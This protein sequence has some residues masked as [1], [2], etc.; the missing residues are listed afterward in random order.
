MKLDKTLHNKSL[1]TTPHWIHLPSSKT[2]RVVKSIDCLLALLI[3][4][5]F[6]DSV[7]HLTRHDASVWH[8]RNVSPASLQCYHPWWYVPTHGPWGQLTN[9]NLRSSYVPWDPSQAT[10]RKRPM[11]KAPGLTRCGMIRHVWGNGSYLYIE[12]SWNIDIV[13]KITST[14]WRKFYS[15]IRMVKLMKV[16]MSSIVCVIILH[17]LN[18]CYMLTCA[19]KEHSS[20]FVLPQVLK[21]RQ[22]TNNARRNIPTSLWCLKTKW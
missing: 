8:R 19:Y 6:V 7:V 21:I 1:P 4:K 3:A 13:H 20:T 15:R 16:D 14:T 22:L 10:S 9:E 2:N 18:V 12:I 17:C 5:C 11:K